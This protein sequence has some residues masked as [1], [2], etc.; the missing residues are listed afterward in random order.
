MNFLWRF[1]AVAVAVYLTINL[2]PGIS[3][4]GGWE[5]VAAGAYGSNFAV[6]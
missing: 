5:K 3:V 6:W 4:A 1:L 2:V